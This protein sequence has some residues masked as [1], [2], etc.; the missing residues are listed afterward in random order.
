MSKHFLSKVPVHALLSRSDVDKGKRGWD[1]NSP[2]F[3]HRAVM[4]LFGDIDGSPRKEANILFRLDRVAG[5]APYFLVQSTIRPIAQDLITGMEVKEMDFPELTAGQIVSFSVALNAVRRK[6]VQ[7]DGK[8]K[9]KIQP[10][11]EDHEIDGLE[12]GETTMTPWLQEKLSSVFDEVQAVAHLRDIL[13]DSPSR[14]A[15][16]IQVDWL[17]GFAQ[18][19]DPNALKEVLAKGIGREKAYGCGLLSVRAV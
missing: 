7:V 17:E 1:I 6:S 5:Q 2:T 12:N 9:V 13:Q 10:V 15:L 16:T 8:R 18:V 11:P 3:R 19:K 4:G 14:S